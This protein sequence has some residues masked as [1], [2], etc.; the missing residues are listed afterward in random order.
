MTNTQLRILSA[1]VLVVLVG[2]CVWAGKFT[3]LVFVGLST[4]FLPTFRRPNAW[5][6]FRF[7]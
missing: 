5:F 6:I 3:A 2:T 1:V 7:Y 4:L